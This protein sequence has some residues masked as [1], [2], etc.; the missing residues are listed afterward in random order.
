MTR[1]E[2]SSPQQKLLRIQQGPREILESGATVLRGAQ[3]GAHRTE[4]LSGWGTCQ[5]GPVNPLD[6]GL[7]GEFRFEKLIEEIPLL[8]QQPV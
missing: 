8:R 1:M 7:V 5:D 2:L 4:F 6:E 3:V